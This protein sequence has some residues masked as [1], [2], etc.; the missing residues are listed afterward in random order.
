M[1][2]LTGL[3]GRKSSDSTALAGCWHLV[4]AEGQPFEPAEADFRDDGTLYY[5]VMSGTRWQIMKL[6]YRVDGE[7]SSPI[8]RRRPEKRGVTSPWRRTVRSSSSS[9]EC[10][11]YSGAE[12]NKHLECRR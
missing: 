7:P 12:R 3:F 5:S 11:A 2:I 10:R 4:R 6:R 9:A 1:G 8:N